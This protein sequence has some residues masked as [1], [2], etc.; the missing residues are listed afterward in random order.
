M[1]RTFPAAWPVCRPGEVPDSVGKFPTESGCL[2]RCGLLGAEPGARGVGSADVG[3]A[4]FP[5][6]PRPKEGQV[7]GLDC[8]A[9]GGPPV[10]L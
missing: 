3:E 8:G 4:G 6:G 7:E 2:V 10:H 5:P 9:S 1:A